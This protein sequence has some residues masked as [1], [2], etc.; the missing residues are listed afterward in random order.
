VCI[1]AL[2]VKNKTLESLAINDN[3]LGAN[4]GEAIGVALAQN[5]TLKSLKI[6][7]NDLKSEGAIQII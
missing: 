7:E 6:S 3:D 2:L 5:S 4:G 1:A